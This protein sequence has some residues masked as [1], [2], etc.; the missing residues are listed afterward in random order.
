MSEVGKIFGRVSERGRGYR[1]KVE[2][3]ASG[4]GSEVGRRVVRF[5]EGA[6]EKLDRVGVERRENLS[7]G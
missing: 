5:L 2:G 6:S 4:A 1:Q 7:D 3:R